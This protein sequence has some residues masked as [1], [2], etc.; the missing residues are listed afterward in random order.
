M[1]ITFDFDAASSRRGIRFLAVVMVALFAAYGVSAYAS[2]V[3]S[4][5]T[6]SAGQPIRAA[7]FNQN[8]TALQTA[9]ND[10]DT[11]IGTL[12][13]LQTSAKTSVVAACN[14]LFNKPGVTGPTG[15][16]GPTGPAGPTLVRLTG[17]AE[18]GAGLGGGVNRWIAGAALAQVTGDP[19]PVTL[20][21]GKPFTATLRIQTADP[22]TASPGA[23]GNPI[24]AGNLVVDLVWTYYAS[25]ASNA[26]VTQAA[27]AT[28]VIT[29]GAP[30][31]RT[32]TFSGT[33]PAAP[34]TAQGFATTMLGSSNGAYVF[35][36][37]NGGMTTA[38]GQSVG[39][40]TLTIT[41]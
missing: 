21:A 26:A 38:T 7:D 29:A 40:L 10:N 37:V 4:L 18:S 23:V 11:R 31:D 27:V 2:Q 33:V 34:A 30:N 16:T 41:P 1:R 35:A 5:V 8:F 36:Q 9:I 12:S 20:V 32:V 13:G 17:V 3:G 28:V 6:F 24:L 22:A 39:S 25:A 14:E 15:A 19:M